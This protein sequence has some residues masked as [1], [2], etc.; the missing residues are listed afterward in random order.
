MA[1]RREL[2]SILLAAAFLLLGPGQ[3]LAAPQWLAA[4]PLPSSFP[5]FVEPAVATDADGNSIAVWIDQDT[6]PGAVLSVYRPRGG[7]WETATVDLETDFPVLAGVAPRAVAVPGGSFVVVWDADRT[8][9]GDTVLRSAT[10]SP[11]GE[12]TTEECATSTP[13]AQTCSR[14]A[15]AA[16]SP[17][18]RPV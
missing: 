1:L 5:A 15:P 4:E 7:P 6:A 2:R 8:A 16:A 11:S 12:W 13:P 18:S 10:R 17:S 3:A 14:R 9:N